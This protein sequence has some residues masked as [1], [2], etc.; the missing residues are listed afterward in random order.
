[1][2]TRVLNRIRKLNFARTQSPRESFALAELDLKLLA[3]LNFQRGTYIEAGANDGIDQ[4]N[5]YYFEKYMDWRGLLVEAIPDLADR[6][7]SNRPNSIVENAALV[8]FGYEPAY[9]DMTYCNLMSIVKG[10]RKSEA[11]DLDHIRRGREVQNIESY[12]L[13]VPARTL[14]SI[15]EQH[16]IEDIDLFSLD[17][18]GFELNVLK[19]IDFDKYRPRFILVEANFRPEIDSF[20][21]PVY[22]PI[23]MLSQLDVLYKAR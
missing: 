2:L 7:R 11:E 1:M 12:E 9:V 13:R 22:E 23:G 15:L 3:Y 18:E 16:K 19:G 8:P 10:A 21:S 20:L 4:S 5:T 14:N 17:V 6:C